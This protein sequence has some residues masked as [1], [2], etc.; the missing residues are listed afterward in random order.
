[1]TW[2]PIYPVLARAVLGSTYIATLPVVPDMGHISRR[3]LELCRRYLVDCG[4]STY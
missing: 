2:I 3:Y 4:L 1:M